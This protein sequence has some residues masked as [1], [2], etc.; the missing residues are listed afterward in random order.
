MYIGDIAKKKSFLVLKKLNSTFRLL[1]NLYIC[2]KICIKYIKPIV[3]I[4]ILNIIFF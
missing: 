4:I 1:A 3:I 2:K